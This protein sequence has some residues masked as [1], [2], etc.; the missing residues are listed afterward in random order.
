M[1]SL[2]LTVALALGA[3][4]PTTVMAQDATIAAMTD[5]PEWGVDSAMQLSLF[6]A[7]GDPLPLQYIVMPLTQ[8]L[9]LNQSDLARGVS[10]GE[11][12]R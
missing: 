4:L 6:T 10:L 5:V 12:P 1:A 3:G 7:V 8:S 9:G 2:L 11:K